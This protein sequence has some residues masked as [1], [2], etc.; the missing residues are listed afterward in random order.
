MVSIPA[1]DQA[2]NAVGAPAKQRNALAVLVGNADL[3]DAVAPGAPQ[4]ARLGHELIARPRRR[5]EVDRGCGSHGALVVRVA[6]KC[7]GTVGE[8]ED[9][10]T[11]TD[12]MAVEHVRAY[13]HDNPRP[14]RAHADN[15]HAERL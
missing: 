6:G 3:I 5:Q 11:V 1:R 15:A 13:R 12:A 9:H 7:K 14:P 8:R 4:L 2:V 10:T